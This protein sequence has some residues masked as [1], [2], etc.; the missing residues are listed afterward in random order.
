MKQI[1][2]FIV[3]LLGQCFYSFGM[4]LSVVS[5]GPA[6]CTIFKHGE[7]ALIY[8]CGY[9]TDTWITHTRFTPAKKNIFTNIMEG[10]TEVGIVISH[11]DADHKNLLPALR[12]FLKEKKGKPEIE[13]QFEI[14][15]IDQRIVPK[16]ELKKL[17]AFFD[18]DFRIYPLIPDFIGD[19]RC[20]TTND[21]SLILKIVNT[22]RTSN[23]G[24]KRKKVEKKSFLMTGDATKKTLEQ[25]TIGK[26]L[27]SNEDIKAELENL[28]TDVVCFMPAHHGT[29]TEDSLVWST[30]VLEHSKFPV[31]TIISS[32]PSVRNH[33]PTLKTIS[34]LN[35]VIVKNLITTDGAKKCFCVPHDINCYYEAF[36]IVDDSLQLSN[37]NWVIP[38]PSFHDGFIVPLFV[39]SNS[40]SKIYTISL[41]PDFKVTLFDNKDQ[42]YAMDD[43]TDFTLLSHACMAYMYSYSQKKLNLLNSDIAKLK[44]SNTEQE[45]INKKRLS[46]TDYWDFFSNNQTKIIENIKTT[47]YLSKIVPLLENIKASTQESFDNFKGLDIKEFNNISFD[48]EF[49][50]FLSSK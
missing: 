45:L 49:L 19:N 30:Q 39:T 43:N 48:S 15:I 22:E 21:K 1:L 29:D 18:P 5:V 10:I 23:K 38:Y 31:L 28:F 50:N 4:Q 46:M 25:I 35:G 13:I 3:F 44:D 2:F 42:L 36:S 26:I 6:N 17:E 41:D 32:D 34:F 16:E 8:D 7:K 20:I 9:S 11:D 14:N 37:D 40:K 27:W 33:T 47:S 24:G 12:F